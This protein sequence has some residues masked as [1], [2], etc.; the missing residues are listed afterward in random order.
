MDSIQLMIREKNLQFKDYEDL[1]NPIG[2]GKQGKVI[3]DDLEYSIKVV[4]AVK[5]KK[6]KFL[7]RSYKNL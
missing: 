7:S 3:K 6:K 5:M 2:E 1:F 4:E